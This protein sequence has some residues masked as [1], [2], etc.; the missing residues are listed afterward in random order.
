MPREEREEPYECRRGS[1]QTQYPSKSK[2]S[3]GNLGVAGWQLSL[4]DISHVSKLVSLQRDA[5]RVITARYCQYKGL[6]PQRAND[7]GGQ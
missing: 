4:A 5:R 1:T 2:P 3:N 7:E 6:G